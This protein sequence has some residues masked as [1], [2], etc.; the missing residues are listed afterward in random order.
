MYTYMFVYVCLYLYFILLGAREWSRF[1]LLVAFW[2]SKDWDQGVVVSVLGSRWREEK[3][4]EGSGRE[5]A[6]MHDRKSEH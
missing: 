2:I 6:V 3:L 4:G 5:E 1:R